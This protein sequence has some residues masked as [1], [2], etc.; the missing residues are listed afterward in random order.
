VIV[1]FDARQSGMVALSLPPFVP[2]ARGHVCN[3]DASI[4]RLC[5]V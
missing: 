1:A 2:S 3:V 4:K 5:S